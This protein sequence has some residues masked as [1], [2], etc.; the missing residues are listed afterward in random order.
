MIK[1]VA[2]LVLLTTSFIATQAG[3]Q[4]TPETA[5]QKGPGPRMPTFAE[6]DLDGDGAIASNEYYEARGARMAARAKE[7]GKM[8]N[9]ANMPAFEDIDLDGN[10]TLSEDEFAAHHA[11][12]GMH[13]GEG[14]R[15]Q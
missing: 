14:K 13:H 9:A 4:C 10:G 12:H 6:F 8:K 5:G 11:S 7:G 1:R 3:A 2:L 15:N